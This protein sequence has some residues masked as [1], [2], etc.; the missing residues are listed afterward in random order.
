MRAASPALAAL[1]A[2]AA[3]ADP[4]T[5]APHTVYV[6]DEQADVIHVIDGR[7]LVEVARIAVGRR[8]RGLALSPD[9]ATLYVAVSN[10]DRIA[11]VSTLTRRVNATLRSGP[12]PE[13]FA[14]SPDGRTLYVANEDDGKVSFLDVATGRL[15][16]E[17]LVGPEP[18]GMAVSPDG[19]WVIC[20]SEAA[21]L[22][23]F[24]ENG[25]L[26]LPQGL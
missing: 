23:H 5:T 21:S 3:C 14:L 19:R 22:V 11:S 2:L 24:I 18:E 16:H 8:P 7:R 17:T 25:G 4:T 12:D 9:G 15:L 1:L 6:S 20:T 13:R 10:D 26:A